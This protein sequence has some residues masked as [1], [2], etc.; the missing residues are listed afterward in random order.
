MRFITRTL[1][2]A[3]AI[4]MLAFPAAAQNICESGPVFNYCTEG[5][6]A[7]NGP[8][9]WH[10]LKT[11]WVECSGRSILQS[12]VRFIHRTRDDSIGPVT[13]HYQSNTA[14]IANTGH[15]IKVYPSARTHYI[16]IK[17]GPYLYLDEFHFHVPAEHQ[18]RPLINQEVAGELHLVHRETSQSDPVAIAVF[19]V[20]QSQ[21][22]TALNP[23]LS[24]AR[25][26]RMCNRE[27]MPFAFDLRQLVPTTLMSGGFFEYGGSLTTPRCTRVHWII[28]AN[29]IGISQRQLDALNLF[30]ANNRPIDNRDASVKCY[31][32]A[33][34][35]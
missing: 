8:A 1:F 14:A 9:N 2:L 30:G 15:A 11:I 21:D 4:A 23:I 26:L 33:C 5:E 18:L 19:L 7:A 16:R 13:L 31:G 6:C 24:L 28:L 29:T 17:N 35:R 12:P 34:T 20:R 3:I 22:N 32:P 27:P 25:E 10:A